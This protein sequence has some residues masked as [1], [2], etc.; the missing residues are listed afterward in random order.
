MTEIVKIRI[1]YSRVTL[2]LNISSKIAVDLRGTFTISSILIM[3]LRTLSSQFPQP[4]NISNDLCQHNVQMQYTQ[5]VVQ[6]GLS[7]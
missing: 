3:A 5:Q 7:F 1:F 4:Y 6:T 2:S